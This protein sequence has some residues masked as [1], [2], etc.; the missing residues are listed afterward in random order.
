LYSR[1]IHSILSL[2]FEY[3]GGSKAG[4]YSYLGGGGFD[5][6]GYGMGGGYLTEEKTGSKG[7]DKK[8]IIILSEF[9]KNDIS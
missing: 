5:P 2:G 3:G 1:K 9:F 8:A 4:G 7:A 6:M